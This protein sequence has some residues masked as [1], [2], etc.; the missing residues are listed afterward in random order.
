MKIGL[1]VQNLKDLSPQYPQI[2]ILTTLLFQ[3]RSYNF[4]SY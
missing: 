2:D 3:E 4:S 1:L